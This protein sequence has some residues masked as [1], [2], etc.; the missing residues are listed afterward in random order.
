MFSRLFGWMKR[1]PGKLLARWTV[2]PDL[3]RQFVAMEAS[4]GTA[5]PRSELPPTGEA[6]PAGVDIL[7]EP[8]AFWIGGKRVAIPLRGTPEVLRAVLQETPHQP[9]TI[10]LSLKYPPY[11]TRSGGMRPPEYTRLAVPVPTSAWREA[12]AVTAHFNRDTPGTPDFFHGR[13]DGSDPED[14]SKCWSCGHETH[15][16][17][18]ECERCGAS[19]Q[20]RRWARRFGAVL[21][22][23]GLFIAGVMGVVLVNMTPLLLQPGVSI[24]GSRFSGSGALAAVVLA[25]FIAL[26]AFGATALSYGV[27]QMA[28]GKRNLRVANVMIAL[29]SMMTATVTLMTWLGT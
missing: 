18:S 2:D 28:T 7:V 14:L 4:R 5:E 27:W 17:R 3:W 21:A 26:F 12:T 13:G 11:W 6:P 20:S 22:L 15:K 9:A 1:K 16:L 29:F 19:L 23:A 24:D 8:H 10:E 25:I